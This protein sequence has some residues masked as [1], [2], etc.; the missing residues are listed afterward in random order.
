MLETSQLRGLSVDKAEKYGKPHWM[1]SYNSKNPTASSVDRYS[2]HE[3]AICAICGKPATNVHHVPPKGVGRLFVLDTPKDSYRLRP[4]LFA[5]CG[6]GTTGCHG[7]FHDGTY[8]IEWKWDLEGLGNG[9]W[10]GSILSLIDAHSSQLYDV[11]CWIVTD[12]N[13]SLI[14]EIRS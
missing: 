13:G 11:G 4:S 5:L 7:K 8:K 14:K 12:R 10:D 2:M 9:W 6:S 1:A 3:D